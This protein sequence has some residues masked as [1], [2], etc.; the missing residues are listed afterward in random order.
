MKIGKHLLNK[1]NKKRL[2]Q[3]EVADY[4]N[5]SQRTYSNFENDNSS[6][7]IKQIVELNNLFEFDF[8]KLYTGLYF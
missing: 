2:S 5:I 6:P 1:R 3:Q 4:L 8:I 7:S